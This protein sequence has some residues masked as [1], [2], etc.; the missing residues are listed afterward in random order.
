[1]RKSAVLIAGPT[2]SGKSEIALSLAETV[3][4]VIINADSMQVYDAL[5]VLTA[6][7]D[8][9]AMARARHE[10]Y[11]FVP[12]DHVYSVGQWLIDV[13]RVL[14]QVRQSGRMPIIVGGTGLYFSG[15]LKGLSPI[16]E[17]EDE[18]RAHWRAEALRCD[19]S[20]LHEQLSARDEAMASRLEPG[21]VQR[22]VRALEVMDST[23]QSL[24]EWQKIPGT[25]LLNFEDVS[26]LVVAP[27]R[28]ELYQKCDARFDAMIAGGAVF[29]EVRELAALGL[30][31]GLPVM[32]ALG[33][34]EIRAHLAGEIS[35]ETAVSDAK[36]ETRRYAKRQL[37][38][39]RRNMISW[40]WIDK[41][42]MEKLN[43]NILSFI[44]L[45]D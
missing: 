31:P 29:D 22:I 27:P 42:F 10:L 19:A 13:E 21:D 28:A 18:V 11:G 12:S 25:P 39:L 44:D 2:A 6:R 23:G 7:P 32:R 34:P 38:W 8:P 24:A 5:P 33:A 3:D 43:G 1:M 14:E 17:I 36:M 15:L 9:M 35:L 30:D 37:T 4:G 45:E 40:K 41:K 20:Q 26:G 16:P